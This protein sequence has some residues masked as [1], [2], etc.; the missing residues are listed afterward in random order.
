M[1]QQAFP[2]VLKELGGYLQRIE[3]PDEMVLLLEQEKLHE[4]YPEEALDFLDK[5]VRDDAGFLSPDNLERCLDTISKVRPELGTE[6]RL[7]R[8]REIRRRQF[9]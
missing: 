2:A 7:V 3:R 1:T 6:F 5:I 4:S 8:L 9:F